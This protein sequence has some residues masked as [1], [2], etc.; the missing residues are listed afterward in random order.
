MRLRMVLF[1]TLFYLLKGRCSTLSIHVLLTGRCSTL[2][3]HILLTGW[4]LSIHVIL[5]GRRSTLSVHILLTG[6]M[7]NS[8]NT[9]SADRG[10]F[11]SCQ[12]MFYRQ[13]VC[14]IPSVQQE[15]CSTLC[16]RDV[17]LLSVHALLTVGMFNYLSMS[18]ICSHP[19]SM[20]WRKKM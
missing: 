7:F 14:S 15:G 8:V 18:G 3:K 12:L 9:Y 2:S 17:Q 13:G 10:M 16:K 19:S 5:T 20:C 11:N 4:S 6:G 1:S